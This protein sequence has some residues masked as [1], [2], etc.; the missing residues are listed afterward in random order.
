MKKTKVL[1][2]DGMGCSGCVHTVEN[3]LAALTGVKTA[4]VNLEEGTAV[5]N[6]DDTEV[7]EEDFKTAV[8]DA[9]YTVS[10]IQG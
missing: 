7:K 2:I 5:V 9:G 6:F 8:E 10:G 3:A 4:I 1:N